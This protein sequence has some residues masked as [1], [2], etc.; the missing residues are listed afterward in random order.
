MARV[1]ILLWG[2]SLQGLR[3]RDL[4]LGPPSTLAEIIRHTCLQSH[5]QRSPPTP[6]KSYLKFRNSRTTFE[7]TPLCPPK[8]SIVR[9][10]GGV[11]N[12]FQGVES[13][14]FCYLGPHVKFLNPRTSFEMTPLFRPKM[15]QCGGVGWVS[16]FVLLIG[17]LIFLLLRSPRKILEPYDNPFW[18]FSNGGTRQEEEQPSLINKF[19]LQ[20]RAAHAI[21]SDQLKVSNEHNFFWGGVG[22]FF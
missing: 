14:Q 15:P 10:V 16:E 18:D 5:L 6:Q 13:S 11:P 12:F 1:K 19:C 9:G 2:S 20:P 4:P 17:I 21:R 8:Y 3:T 7:N 22:T